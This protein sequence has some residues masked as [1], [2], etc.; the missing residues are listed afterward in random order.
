M[1]NTLSKRLNQHHAIF[2]II[3]LAILALD[4]LTK[5]L[6]RATF[7]LH[8]TKTIISSIFSLTYSTNTGAAFGLLQNQTWFFIWLSVMVLGFIIYYYD[9]ISKKISFVIPTALVL[10]GVLGNFF[11]RIVYGQVI[12]FLDFH[13]WPILNFLEKTRKSLLLSNAIFQ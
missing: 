6:I 3:A 7:S 8:E 10:G 9:A 12:D 1:K 2:F 5:H 4:Q 13:I 11:D